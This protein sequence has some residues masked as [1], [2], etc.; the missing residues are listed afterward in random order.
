MQP[1]R[2]YR[3][4]TNN[5]KT[6]V[7]FFLR[8]TN[9]VP[10]P[11]EKVYTTHETSWILFN[12]R[13]FTENRGLYRY[14]WVVLGKVRFSFVIVLHVDFKS[15][16]H[17]EFI[18]VLHVEFTHAIRPGEK[19]Q[20]AEANPTRSV[21][22]PFI[23]EPEILRVGEPSTYLHGCLLRVAMSLL[24][25]RVS[26][27]SQSVFCVSSVPWMFDHTNIFVT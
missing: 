27:V 2:R 10:Y 25:L 23:L 5:T 12:R 3:A 7:T 22:K 19:C 11:G 8:A 6:F 21:N 20:H 26:A 9:S 17:V 4:T 13:H 14:I 1:W 16:L 18:H 15:V 24:C